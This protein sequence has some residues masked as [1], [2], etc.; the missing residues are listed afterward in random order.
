MD[1]EP[2]MTIIG[3]VLIFSLVLL[4]Q[5]AVA[6]MGH[7]PEEQ[8]LVLVHIHTTLAPM[9]VSGELIQPITTLTLLVVLVA[10]VV[11]VKVM[12]ARM[13]V[14]RAAERPAQTLVGAELVVRAAHGVRLAQRAKQAEREITAVVKAA[15][16]VDRPDII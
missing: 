2:S 1:K 11:A 7:C 16:L 9:V 4:V 5:K 3:R 8:V 10:L 6:I 14:V 15:V 12:T 13:P